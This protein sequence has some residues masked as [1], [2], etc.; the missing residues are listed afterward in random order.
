METRTGALCIIYRT[1]LVRLSLVAGSVQVTGYRFSA[2][3]YSCT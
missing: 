1:R 2:L 3:S